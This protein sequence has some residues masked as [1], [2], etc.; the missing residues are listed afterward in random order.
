VTDVVLIAVIVAFFVAG[1]GV[2]RLLDGMIANSG[3]DADP[4]D[5]AELEPGEAELERG[6]DR[7]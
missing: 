2:V 4:G 3:T 1:A 6:G 5:E 7:R